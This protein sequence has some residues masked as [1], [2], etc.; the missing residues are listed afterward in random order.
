MPDAK[1]KRVLYIELLRVIAAAAVV[2][3]HIIAGLVRNYAVSTADWDICVILGSEIRWCIPLF[4]MISGAVFLD[5]EQHLPLKTMLG[6]YVL[7]LLTALAVWGTF[8]YF[9][10]LWIYGQP[11]TMKNVV[12]APPAVLAGKAGYHLWYLYALIPIYLL[13]PALKAF[14]GHSTKEQQ[15]SLLVI[16]FTLSSIFPLFNSVAGQIPQTRGAISIGVS[17]PEAFAYVA[18]VLAGYYVAH[19]DLDSSEEKI[20]R[21]IAIFSILCMPV[22]NIVLSVLKNDLEFSLSEYSGICSVSVAG[23]LFA[24]AKR[25]EEYLQNHPMGKTALKIGGSCFGIYLLH[26]FFVSILFHKLPVPWGKIN[27]MAA[28]L[29]GTPVVFAASYVL[30]RMMKKI[31]FFRRIL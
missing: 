14:T 10:E 26:V 17:L 7:R 13:I 29:T 16:L 19:F 3:L 25:Q 6:K 27:A 4:F 22:G 11:V 28:V 18:C 8:F 30:T 21:L 23:W 12:L 9:F 20:L 5:R 2:M 24:W 1:G 15:R 31:P